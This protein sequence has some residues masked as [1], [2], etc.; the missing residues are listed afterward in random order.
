MTYQICELVEED[1]AWVQRTRDAT[2]A[3]A[4]EIDARKNAPTPVPVQVT[5]RQGMAVLIKHGLDTPIEAAL[6]S[7]LAAAQQAGDA[8][9]ILRAKLALNDYASSQSFERRWPLIAAMQ[10]AFGW[11][12][13]YVD[14]LFVE[15]A[16]L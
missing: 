14:S 4:A 6:Q 16:T 2:P 11:T 9:A 7:Q 15:A 5:R 3:E 8:A 10:Q 12:D 13:A 1:G